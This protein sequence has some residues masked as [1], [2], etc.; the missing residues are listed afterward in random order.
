VLG[1]VGAELA[2][3]EAIKDTRDPSELAAYLEQ[4]PAGAFTA[5]AASTR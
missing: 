2:F 4:Y 3:W 1:V 5:L